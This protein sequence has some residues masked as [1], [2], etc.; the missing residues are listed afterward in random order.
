MHGERGSGAD[1]ENKTRRVVT[2]A[3]VGRRRR[4]RLGRNRRSRSR[5]RRLGR[6]LS[7]P[8]IAVGVGRSGTGRRRSRSGPEDLRRRAERVQA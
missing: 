4:R 5:R 2:R 7:A 3:R 1:S 8:S 6:L